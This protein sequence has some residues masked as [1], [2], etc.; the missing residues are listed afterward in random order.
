MIIESKETNETSP[1]DF[2][3]INSNSILMNGFNTKRFIGM[4]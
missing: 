3:K 4:K 2:K 1:L